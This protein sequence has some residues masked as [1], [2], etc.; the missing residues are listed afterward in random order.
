[1][2]RS[3]PRCLLPLLTS[4]LLW[5]CCQLLPISYHLLMF[6][7]CCQLLHHRH[8]SCGQALTWALHMLG[9]LLCSALGLHV[10]YVLLLLLLLLLIV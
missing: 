5:L 10:A 3:A 7:P 8:P 6:L 9:H 1:M 4:C 2:P